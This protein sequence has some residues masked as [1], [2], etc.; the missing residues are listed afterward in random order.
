MGAVLEMIWSRFGLLATLALLSACGNSGEGQDYS[1]P[2]A[3][4][5]AKFSAA[6]KK[7]PTLATLDA[8]GVAT[9]RQALE[10]DRQPIYLVVNPVLKYLN[11]M[12]PYGQNGGVITWSSEQYETISMRDGVVVATRGFGADLMTSVAP[13][14]ASLAAGIGKTHREFYYLDG[15][16]QKAVFTFDCTLHSAGTESINILGK[17]FTARKVVETCSG[18]NGGFENLFWFDQG[19]NIRQSSQWTAPVL[20]N[21]SLQRVI[22]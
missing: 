12:A 6:A 4:L 1:R 21:F 20:N 13:T 16:D 18:P 5:V 11:L 10:K 22:D 15:A 2:T 3:A 7:G 17:G 19:H 9:L 8:N 14:A